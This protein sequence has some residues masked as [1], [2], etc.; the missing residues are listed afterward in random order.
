MRRRLILKEKINDFEAGE[1]HVLTR[2]EI[3]KLIDGGAKWEREWV[4]EDLMNDD[5]FYAITLEGGITSIRYKDSDPTCK[6]LLL[7]KNCYETEMAA[8]IARQK[9]EEGAIEL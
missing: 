9:I 6:W 5:V 1:Y 2:N 7:T 3:K 4:P 8:D